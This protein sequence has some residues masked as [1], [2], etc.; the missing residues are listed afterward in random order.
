[1]AICWSCHRAEYHDYKD[2]HGVRCPLCG[3][4]ETDKPVPVKAQPAAKQATTRRSK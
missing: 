3:Q 1:M 2:A 4:R